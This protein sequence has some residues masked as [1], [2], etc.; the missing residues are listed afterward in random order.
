M[1]TERHTIAVAMDEVD[2]LLCR[3][4]TD[5]VC[6]SRDQR[7][8]LTDEA[9]LLASVGTTLES[10]DRLARGLADQLTSAT[11]RGAF[12]DAARHL[13][14]ALDA[15]REGRGRAPGADGE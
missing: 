9:D 4:V 6:R 14:A 2:R 12:H 3:T 1:G 13:S 15:V 5:P 8:R 10:L 11:S 7:F